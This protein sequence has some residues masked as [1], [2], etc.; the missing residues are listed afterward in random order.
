[1]P[2]DLQR[3]RNAA[4]KWLLPL[5]RLRPAQGTGAVVAILDPQ[6]LLAAM[7][8]AAGGLSLDLALFDR[9]GMLLAGT[10]PARAP[11]LRE[12]GLWVFAQAPVGRTSFTWRGPETAPY[13]RVVIGALGLTA[14]AGLLAVATQPADRILIDTGAFPLL[15]AAGLGVVAALSMVLMAL[16]LRQAR[17]AVLEAERAHDRELLAMVDGRAKQDFLAA[18]SHEIRTPMNGVIGM[19]GLLLDTNLD[20]EQRRYGETIQSSA[21]HLLTVLNDV[22]DFSKIEAQAVELESTTFL[23]EEEVA[24]IAELFGPSAAAKGAEIVC[25]PTNQLAIRAM[26]TRGGA[27]VTVVSDGAAAV[28]EAVSG[29]YDVVLMDLQMPGMDGLAATRALRTAERSGRHQ[30]IIGLAAAIG[31]VMALECHRAGMDS[32]LSKPVARDLLTTVG[33]MQLAL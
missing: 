14:T 13:G 24:T 19:G 10:D 23:V 2:G 3:D 30:Y 22:L 15:L 12:R 4:R 8:P 6:A 5:G 32:Y 18:M 20:P 7:R 31:L 33:R 11:G 17:L 21:A 26:L 28:P 29:E 25:R 16:L 9:E 27:T 1:M